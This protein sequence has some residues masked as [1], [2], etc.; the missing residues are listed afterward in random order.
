MQ[1]KL[2]V[3]QADKADSH[4]MWTTQNSEN[5]GS[6]VKPTSSHRIGSSARC[7]AAL[8]GCHGHAEGSRPGLLVLLFLLIR[9]TY[10]DSHSS[11]NAYQDGEQVLAAWQGTVWWLSGQHIGGVTKDSLITH[12][13]SE[14]ASAA[15]D[16]SP[17]FT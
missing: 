13:M 4:N 15:R 7:M 11:R 6:N 2:K 10:K 5:Q 16:T 14:Q 8:T 3:I 17:N 1:R 12:G 9:T